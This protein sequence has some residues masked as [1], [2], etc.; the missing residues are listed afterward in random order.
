M[1]RAPAHLSKKGKALWKKIRTEYAINDSGG[2][3]LL[4]NACEAYDRINECQQT[5]DNDGLTITDRYG[6]TKVH[7]LC[8]VQRDARS[9]FVQSIKLL[10]LDLEPLK[11][12]GR[13]PGS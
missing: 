2:L 12:I 10:N 3:A 5:L 6:Q 1:V 11:D 8:S 13:P 4:T 7:P 9:Q